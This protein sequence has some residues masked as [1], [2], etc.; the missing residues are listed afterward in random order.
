MSSLRAHARTVSVCARAE[1]V[2]RLRRGEPIRPDLSEL[3]APL[4]E[5]SA[6]SGPNYAE[7]GAGG[8]RP[9]PLV[10][11]LDADLLKQCLSDC[12][13]PSARALPSP[14]FSLTNTSLAPLNFTHRKFPDA[15]ESDLFSD[16]SLSERSA[17]AFLLVTRSELEGQLVL[18]PAFSSLVG[19]NSRIGPPVLLRVNKQAI[20]VGNSMFAILSCVV[21]GIVLLM[22]PLPVLEE[23]ATR[24]FEEL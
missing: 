24:R 20:Y 22:A 2:A 16:G 8:E 3:D 15:Y 4:E 1:I 12:W 6:A 13:D 21:R 14:L 19:G 23:K 7:F 18:L 11:H 17:K 5:A 10:T 9:R